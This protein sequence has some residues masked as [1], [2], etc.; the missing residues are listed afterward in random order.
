[1]YYVGT[2]N[3]RKHPMQLDTTLPID[4]LQRIAYEHGVELHGFTVDRVMS[5]GISKGKTRMHFLLRPLPGDAGEHTRRISRYGRRLWACTWEAHRDFM[6]V[7]FERDPEAV[8]R[9]A[10]ATYIGRDGFQANFRSTQGSYF[11]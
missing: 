3:E 4:R 9:T 1:M 5:R 7:L 2:V 10:L 8:L 6:A 11:Q